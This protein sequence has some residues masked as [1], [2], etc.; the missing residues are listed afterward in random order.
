MGNFKI[1]FD[2][3]N[4]TEG[5]YADNP[6]D[7]G[8]ET[9][10]GISRNN[11]PNWGG[12]K[13]VD[14]A[15]EGQTAPGLI[16]RILNNN[17]TVQQS[18]QFFYKQNFWEVLKLDQINDQQ[19]CNTVYDFGVNSGTGKSAKYLQVSLNQSGSDLDIDGKIGQRTIDAI[20]SAHFKTV[21][22]DFNSLRK[23][24]YTSLAD[25]PS[26]V[27]FLHSWLSRLA[28]YQ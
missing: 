8:G 7:S 1:S 24:F 28:P 16:S 9:Y 18:V 27:Q 19:I 20:N 2:I 6:D 25:N 3:T 13:Y 22:N 26:Q 21:Y 10:A 14:L 17:T 4:K 11:W 5:G 12:W 23:S 15:K